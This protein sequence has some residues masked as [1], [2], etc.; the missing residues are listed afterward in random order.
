MDWDAAY[1]NRSTVDNFEDFLNRWTRDAAAFRESLIA[2]GHATINQ[3]YGSAERNRFDLFLP[4]SSPLGLVVF[5]HGG[6][7]RSLD[8]SYWS[9][10]SQGCLDHGWAFAIPGYTLAPQARIQEITREITGAIRHLASRVD[11]PIRLSGHSAGGHLVS[12]MHCR[13]SGLDPSTRDRIANTVAVSGVFDL[14]HLPKTAMNA[15]LQIDANDIETESPARLLPHDGAR[16]HCVVGGDEL[17]EFRRQNELLDRWNGHGATVT[18][19]TA[20]GHNHFSIVEPLAK[21]D[22]FLVRAL[23][24]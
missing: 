8:K 10:L 9:H 12:R 18:T 13:D 23:L 21:A 7:W 14:E 17:A 24:G 11:G 22:S 20:S 4:K 5:I 3:Q 1:N 19:Q 2:T 15:D 6:Y 16:I